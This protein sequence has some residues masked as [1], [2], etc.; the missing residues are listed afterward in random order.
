MHNIPDPDSFTSISDGQ[1]VQGKMRLEVY[2][3]PFNS[4]VKIMVRRYA[5]GVWRVSLKIY[6]ISGKLVK[7]FTPYASRITPYSF[8]WNASTLPAGIYLLKLNVGQKTITKKL[9]LQK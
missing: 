6:D 8:A 1:S 5:Y 4:A 2:P 3:N 9:F 7:D